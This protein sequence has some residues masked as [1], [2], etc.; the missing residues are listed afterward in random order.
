MRLQ[1]LRKSLTNVSTM[2]TCSLVVKA[3]T[4]GSGWRDKV[5]HPT[6]SYSSG[7]Y[8]QESSTRDGGALRRLILLFSARAFLPKLQP[9][10]LTCWFSVLFLP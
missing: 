6:S 2:S 3:L 5:K 8:V 10:D 1:V 7:M 4:H 9:G